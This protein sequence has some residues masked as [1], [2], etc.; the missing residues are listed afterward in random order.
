MAWI[1]KDG[2][3]VK[4]SIPEAFSWLG[5]QQ[6]ANY[7]E[8][9]FCWEP[10]GVAFPACFNNGVSWVLVCFGVFMGNWLVC[11]NLPTHS[12]V[13]YDTLEEAMKEFDR[14]VKIAQGQESN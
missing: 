12:W 5:V 10:N 7:Q 6:D 8:G 1:I 13:H 4:R 3:K 11:H 2:E 9:V 14:I